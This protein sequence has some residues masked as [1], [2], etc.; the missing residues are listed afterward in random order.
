MKE[1]KRE[2]RKQFF[3]RYLSNAI[4]DG[5]AAETIFGE[6]EAVFP[7]LL[8]AP[9]DPDGLISSSCGDHRTLGRHGHVKDAIVVAKELSDFAEGRVLP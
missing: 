8:K 1:K 2:E 4:T 6:V 3:P 9:P 5:Y 7:R